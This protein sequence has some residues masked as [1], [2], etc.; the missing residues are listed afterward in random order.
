M[1]D[2]QDSGSCARQGVEVQVL[3]TALCE[4]ARVALMLRV[5]FYAKIHLLAVLVLSSMYWRSAGVRK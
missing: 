3:S 1:A 5:F 4:K 2:A